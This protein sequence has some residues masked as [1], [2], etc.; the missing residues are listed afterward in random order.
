LIDLLVQLNSEGVIGIME[1]RAGV[2]ITLINHRH[3]HRQQLRS[4]Q[5][6]KS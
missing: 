5:L 4:Y 2:L 1:T 3:R 6:H